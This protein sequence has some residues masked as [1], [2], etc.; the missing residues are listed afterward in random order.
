MIGL[1]AVDPMTLGW[2]PLG[3]RRHPP[4]IHMMQVRTTHLTFYS[5]AH[6]SSMSCLNNQFR[7]GETFVFPREWRQDGV[8]RRAGPKKGD[9][10]IGARY[11][12]G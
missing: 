7:H 5:S 6:C 12:D 11:D 4:P 2:A 10:M 8:K 3:S 1:S 9:K